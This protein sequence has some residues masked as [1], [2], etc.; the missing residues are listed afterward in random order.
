MKNKETGRTREAFL[1]EA[2]DL[3][4]GERARDYGPARK[5]HE[6]IADIW[7]VVLQQKLNTSLSP[8]D[9]VACMIGLKLARLSQD[10]TKDDSWRD[11]IGYAALGGEMIND[12]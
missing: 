6:R 8:E 7:S 11:I 10:I 2:E 4:N 9:V 5:N 3:I 12:D 1:R